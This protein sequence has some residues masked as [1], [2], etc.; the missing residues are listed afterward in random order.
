MVR[1]NGAL[2]RYENPNVRTLFL[3]AQERS[4]YRCSKLFRITNPGSEICKINKAI[5]KP[6]VLIIG[7]SHADQ[8]DEMIAELGEQNSIPVYL[9]VRNCTSDEFGVNAHC[10]QSI[11][12]EILTEIKHNNITAV[13]STS[14]WDSESLNIKGFKEHLTILTDAGL[15]VYISETVPHAEFLILPCELTLC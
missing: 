7:D 3:A 4:P 13:I 10:A 15:K 9:T 8:L 5:D 12:D 14:Y 1:T 11:F 6:G 2:F